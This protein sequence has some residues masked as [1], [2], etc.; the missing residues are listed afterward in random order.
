VRALR[1][2]HTRRV[3][4]A[5]ILARGVRERHPRS[6]DTRWIQSG[7]TMD[8]TWVRAGYTRSARATPTD[9]TPPLS[10]SSVTAPANPNDPPQP[11]PAGAPLRATRKGRPRRGALL[12]EAP[13]SIP[14]PRRILL[15]GCPHNKHAR[16]APWVHDGYIMDTHWIR[17]L[18]IPRRTSRTMRAR[19]VVASK[20]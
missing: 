5:S 10:N 6:L 13:R 1:T 3:H 18:R 19:H 16:N 9:H 20:R 15:R 12:L 7:Y 4:S 17:N 2:P 8:T 14:A 11:P